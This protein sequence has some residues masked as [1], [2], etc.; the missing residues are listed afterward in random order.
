V[1]L[2]S[3]HFDVLGYLRAN[4]EE[5]YLN[6]CLF[7]TDYDASVECYNQTGRPCCLTNTH[8]HS[9]NYSNLTWHCG[10]HFKGWRHIVH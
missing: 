9:V 3:T 7:H 4:Q 6:E 5:E 1:D 8:T 10:A 2:R